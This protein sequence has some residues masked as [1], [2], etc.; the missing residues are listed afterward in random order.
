MPREILVGLTASRRSIVA[1]GTNSFLGW[2]GLR[3]GLPSHSKDMRMRKG[4][5]YDGAVTATVTS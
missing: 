4:I 3:I 1:Q 5:R 2:D